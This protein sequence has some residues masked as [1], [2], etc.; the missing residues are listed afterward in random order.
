MKQ[1]KLFTRQ[2]ETKGVAYKESSLF[3]KQ[4]KPKKPSLTIFTYLT[5]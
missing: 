5:L 3:K 2:S 4:Y 1:L